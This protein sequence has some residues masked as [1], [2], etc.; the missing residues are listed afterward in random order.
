MSPQGIPPDDGSYAGIRPEDSCASGIRPDP[1]FRLHERT[2]VFRGKVVT[3]SVDRIRLPNGHETVHEVLHLPSAVSIVPLLEDGGNTH[4]VLVEQFRNSVEGYIHE[5]PA[6]II[7]EGEDPAVCAARELEEETG[8]RAATLS[9]LGVLLPIPGTS[10]HRMHFF[11][12]EG[13][14]PGESRLERSECLTVRRIPL[15]DLVRGILAAGHPGASGSVGEPSA[16]VSAGVRI[17]DAKTQI[18]ILHVAL[19]KGT[20]TGVRKGDTPGGSPGSATRPL[21]LPPSR[22]A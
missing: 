20:A 11:L 4:V 5:V 18:G 8:Y 22:T 19:R 7:E 13:L 3:V 17:V 1:D 14:T 21:D 12:A 6:G 15:D 16:S 10:S 9:P 2:I